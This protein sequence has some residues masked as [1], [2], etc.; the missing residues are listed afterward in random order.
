MTSLPIVISDDPGLLARLHDGLG[1]DDFSPMEWRFSVLCDPLQP[2]VIGYFNRAAGWRLRESLR[3]SIGRHWHWLPPTRMRRLD[4]VSGHAGRARIPVARL[5]QAWD[6]GLPEPA[7]VESLARLQS[8][9][10]WH[11][12]LGFGNDGMVTIDASRIRGIDQAQRQIELPRIVERLVSDPGIWDQVGR[13]EGL[14]DIRVRGHLTDLLDGG[15]PFDVR[16][17]LKR[18]PRVRRCADVRFAGRFHWSGNQNGFHFSIASQID[19]AN[20]SAS[21]PLDDMN[22]LTEYVSSQF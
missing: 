12:R 13:C 15:I 11:E 16:W 5:W 21:S 19:L 4:T 2:Q 9:R 1:M 10:G 22:L 7:S 3:A 17:K 6:D 14:F 20:S 18:K 8:A